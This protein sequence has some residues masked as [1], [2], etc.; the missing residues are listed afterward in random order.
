MLFDT[1][2]KYA[3][4]ADAADSL[5][6]LRRHFYF[7]GHGNKNSVYLCGNSLGLLSK[8]AR[9][10]IAREL[11]DWGALAVGG[12]V[13][14]KNPWLFYHNYFKQ[15]LAAIVGCRVDEVTVMNSLTVNLHLLMVSF[16]RPTGQRY[17]I[18]MEA[19]AFPSD[20]YAVETQTALHG[21]PPESIIEVQPRAGEKLLRTEDIVQTIRD[22]ADTLALVLFGGINYYTGQLYDMKTITEAAHDAGAIAGFDLAHVAGNVPVHLHDWNVDFAVWCSYKYLNGGPGAVGGAYIH[23]KYANDTPPWRLVGK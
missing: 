16:Y 7:P 4:K 12:Y 15:S 13:H 18:V 19:G 8:N 6:H 9:K 10:A 1:T 17:K 20:Q 21:Y 11:K 14:A 2:L 3:R 22:H 23:E 5:G